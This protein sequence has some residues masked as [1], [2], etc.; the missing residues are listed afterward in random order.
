[1]ARTEFVAKCTHFSPNSRKVSL[2]GDGSERDAVAP[3]AVIGAWRK[4]IGLTRDVRPIV[5]RLT[6]GKKPPGHCELS[7]LY[8][9]ALD[10]AFHNFQR[11]GIADF[12]AFFFQ[13]A[14]AIGFAVVLHRVGIADLVN[15]GPD[16]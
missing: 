7:H 3:G 14:A 15:G 11:D 13:F 10:I 1:M 2:N 9:E 4:K 12:N 16:G 6:D 8:F 5:L